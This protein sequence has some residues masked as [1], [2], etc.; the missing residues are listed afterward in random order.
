M[1]KLQ[2]EKR[3][4]KKITCLVALT[5]GVVFSAQ[6]QECVYQSRT[7]TNNNLEVSE[8]SN[9]TR[10]IIDVENGNRK[11]IVNFSIRVGNEWHMASGEWEWSGSRPHQEACAKAIQV[12][13]QEAI[14][15]IADREVTNQQV[16]ICNDDE[17]FSRIENISVGTV[18]S[19]EQFWPHPE[20][21]KPFYHEG[22]RCRWIVGSRFTGDNIKRHDGIICE[23]SQEKWVVVDKF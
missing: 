12:A 2:G 17:R 22:T 7:V 20:F 14:E 10:D 19:I 6:S 3:N 1:A 18:G 8:R 4:M 21:D 11:C 15:R 16:L 13:E 5:F 23:V 9:I